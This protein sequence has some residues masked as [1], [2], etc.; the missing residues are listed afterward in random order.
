LL[1]I[2]VTLF[3]RSKKKFT[4]YDS[5]SNETCS[6]IVLSEG[7][8]AIKDSPHIP[9]QRT[10]LAAAGTTAAL[11]VYQICCPLVLSLVGPTLEAQCVL[12][13]AGHTGMGG[14]LM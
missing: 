4:N 14:H 2:C 12:G 8:E 7:T 6:V 10:P 1:K 3:N 9:W 5:C 11:V 13:N